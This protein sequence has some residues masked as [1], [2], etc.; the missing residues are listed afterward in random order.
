MKYFSATCYSIKTNS[1]SAALIWEQ[2]SIPEAQFNRSLLS[3]DSD[4]TLRDN[5][6]EDSMLKP[7][8]SPENVHILIICGF[9]ILEIVVH[10]YASFLPWE[11]WSSQ[12]PWTLMLCPPEDPH[13]YCFSF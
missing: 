4:D 10:L 9:A 6:P 8:K 2:S 3:E 11:R 5:H 7:L 12:K 1:L 13:V